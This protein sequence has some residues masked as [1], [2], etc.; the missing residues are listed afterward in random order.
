MKRYLVIAGDSYYPS[1]YT[2]DW[3]GSFDELSEAVEHAKFLEQTLD[4]ACVVD[5]TTGEEGWG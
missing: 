1:T 5:L 2:G 4:W 3:R